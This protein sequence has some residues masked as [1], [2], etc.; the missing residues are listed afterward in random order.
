MND[1]NICL[2]TTT[3]SRHAA[4]S[5]PRRKSK[6]HSRLTADGR[7]LWF[8]CLLNAGLQLSPLLAGGGL[9][10]GSGSCEVL[11]GLSSLAGA[12]LLQ[13]VHLILQVLYFRH[14]HPAIVSK[15]QLSMYQARISACT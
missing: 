3:W 7:G 8:A 13:F 11:I 6:R 9:C 14:L 10:S 1:L 4:E 12:G 15:L 5:A 2:S